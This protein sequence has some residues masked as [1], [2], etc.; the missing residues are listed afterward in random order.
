METKVETVKL[1]PSAGPPDSTI[2]V[3]GKTGCGKSTLIA[4]LLL[5][6]DRFLIFDTRDEYDPEYFNDGT[7]QDTTIVGDMASLVGALN[8]NKKRIVLRLDESAFTEKF[9][10]NA[11]W[12]LVQFKRDNPHIPLTVAMDELNKFVNVNQA[13]SGLKEIIQRGRAFNIQKIFGAQ[14]FNSVP[15][16]L[17]DSVSEIYVYRHVDPRGLAMLSGFGF[18]PVDVQSLKPFTVL[19][20]TKYGD[21]EAIEYKAEEE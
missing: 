6:R 14:W 1:L 21:I 9:V 12:L 8:D 2:I 18:Q 11:C 7:R 13:P 20:L 4:N 17:R 10:N 16:W 5:D 19:H 15:T 3:L